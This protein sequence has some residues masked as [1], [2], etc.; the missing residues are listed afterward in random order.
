MTYEVLDRFP[1][2]ASSVLRSETVRVG[3]IDALRQ[4]L[5]VSGG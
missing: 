5:C 1:P 4:N 3:E 2:F